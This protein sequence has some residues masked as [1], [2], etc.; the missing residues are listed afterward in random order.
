MPSHGPPRI[1]SPR[2][3][4][5]RRR[6]G[7]CH[8]FARHTVSGSVPG[9]TSPVPGGALTGVSPRFSGKDAVGCPLKGHQHV[10]ILPQ[11]R[12][13]DGR[14]DHV[15]VIC[16]EALDRTE[17]LALD[18][19]ET[20]WRS[21]GKPD[22]RMVPIRWG[23][24][25][26]LLTPAYRF[27]SAT[28]LVLTRHYRR[29][30]GEFVDWLAAEM[31]RELHH[32]GL[33]RR[34]RRGFVHSST[35]DRSDPANTAPVPHSRSSPSPVIDSGAIEG[36]CG[37][38]VKDRRERAGCVRP[39]PEQS[40]DRAHRIK[41]CTRHGVGHSW[42]CAATTAVRPH[43]HRRSRP[44]AIILRRAPAVGQRGARR[45]RHR[46]LSTSNRGQPRTDR[47]GR[48]RKDT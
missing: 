25:D 47:H 6:S 15:L 40:A 45:L 34:I 38:V 23:S 31:S 11:D 48:Q 27:V 5:N 36:A 1:C 26:Q 24:L 7:S 37:S 17:Q 2:G 43:Q 9:D 22:V 41:R 30:R 44:E 10:Y 13:R 32:H 3:G 21:H 18:R 46:R 12:N 20:I 14:L 29:G 19:L 39:W 16:K 35:A 8:T 4:V 42:A 28:P 33:P